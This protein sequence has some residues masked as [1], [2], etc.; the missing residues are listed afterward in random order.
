MHGAVCIMCA[1]LCVC[2][3]GC[4][5][6]GYCDRLKTKGFQKELKKQRAKSAMDYAVKCTAATSEKQWK[7]L[8]CEKYIALYHCNFFEN[9]WRI[10]DDSET[11]TCNAHNSKAPKQKTIL[12]L[13]EEDISKQC[14][15]KQHRKEQRKTKCCSLQAPPPS[16]GTH[17]RKPDKS[18][19]FLL[20]L[21][22]GTAL[23]W[24]Y[25]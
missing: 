13:E 2:V 11:I 21:M 16:T 23:R 25:T 22:A 15:H 4:V 9:T 18:H 3:C 17:D 8:N 1:C 5:D 19:V 24:M 10:L 20:G 6:R 12:H 14:M 7:R